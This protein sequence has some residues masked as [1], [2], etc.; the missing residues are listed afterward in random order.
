MRGIV[1]VFL[2]FFFST[3]PSV[4][5]PISVEAERP[6]LSFHTEP[7]AP[8]VGQ[9]VA[10]F[11]QVESDISRNEIVLEGNLD[12]VPVKLTQTG[13]AL[14][15][16]S[17]K[18]FSE[19]KSYNF[20]VDIF[21]RDANES[22]RMRKAISALKKEILAL[23]DAINLEQDPNKKAALTAERDQ[24][25]AYQT[26]LETALDNLKTFLKSESYGFEVVAD[27]TNVNFPVLQSVTPNTVPLNKR[28]QVT[29]SGANFPANPHVKIGGQNASVL[30]ATATSIRV[31]APSFDT[32]GAQ[33]IE[34]TFPAADSE[35]KK[36]AVLSDSFFVSDKAILKNL[37]PVAV[38]TGYQ[39]VT[40]PVTAPV[41]LDATKS[42]DE[43]GDAFSFE[44]VFTRAPN[45]S[46][47]VDGTLLPDSPTPSF[48][49]DKVG[50]YTVRLRLLETA[51]DELLNSFSNTVTIEVK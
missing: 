23:N 26:E 21:V 5:S 16:A 51:T 42:Y 22:K 33:G 14:W 18:T 48:T 17:F 13:D 24:K 47:F 7:A 50:V 19:V 9:T 25:Q 15:I 41:Q 20:H 27:P 49:P 28:I 4:A 1:W 38:T 32:T 2:L 8:K 3:L 39:K 40:A 45:G 37:R 30:I 46:S 11:V 36:N 44:W 31:L 12:S 34:V 29:L 43:N 35:P 6:L 10:V